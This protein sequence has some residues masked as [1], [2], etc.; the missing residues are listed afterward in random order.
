MPHLHF[1]R[2]LLNP[3]A[4][5]IAAEVLRDLQVNGFAFGGFPGVEVEPT[6]TG[7]RARLSLGPLLSA[8]LDL[9]AAQACEMGECFAWK[10]DAPQDLHRR[11]QDLVIELEAATGR[12]RR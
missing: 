1:E 12:A 2:G 8:W 3:I 4:G 7:V 9:T 10:T 5:A 6:H 11:I